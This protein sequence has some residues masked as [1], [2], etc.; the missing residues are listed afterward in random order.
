MRRQNNLILLQMVFNV[1]KLSEPTSLW[2]ETCCSQGLPYWPE[3]MSLTS[4][5]LPHYTRSLS[6]SLNFI[7]SP[8]ILLFCVLSLKKL[9]I[10]LY[11]LSFTE[12]LLWNVQWPEYRMPPPSQ[13][14]MIWFLCFSRYCDLVKFS[15]F[16]FQALKVTLPC[17]WAMSKESIR[18]GFK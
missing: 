9:G 7:Y 1:P 16:F 12:T 13:P 3:E 17:R 10:Y 6:L 5:S 14:N 2:Q 11:T 18:K 15:T 8:E 4:A